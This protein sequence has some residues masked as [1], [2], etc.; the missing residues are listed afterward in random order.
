MMRRTYLFALMIALLTLSGCSSSAGVEERF[1][2]YRETLEN[3]VIT[4]TVELYADFGSSAS[5]YTMQCRVDGASTEMT[6]VEPAL[7]AGITVRTADGGVT[8][9][10]DG[11]SISAGDLT[12]EGLTPVSVLPV[13]AD[14]L[15]NGHVERIWKEKLDGVETIAVSLTVTDTVSQTIWLSQADMIPLYAE[16]QHNGRTVATCLFT[17]WSVQTA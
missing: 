9:E 8:L 10:Y 15:Q 17:G 4:V 5:E 14:S 12:G 11:V 3:S 16:V 6:I 1:L 13:V 2:S 7:L